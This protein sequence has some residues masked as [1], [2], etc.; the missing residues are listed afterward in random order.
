MDSQHSSLVWDTMGQTFPMP[1]KGQVTANRVA[2]IDVNCRQLKRLYLEEKADFFV[3]RSKKTNIV[4]LNKYP[5]RKKRGRE[6]VKRAVL[7]LWHCKA[8]RPKGS[9]LPETGDWLFDLQKPFS[10]LSSSK[11]LSF[12]YRTTLVGV[13]IELHLSLCPPGDLTVSQLLLLGYRDDAQECL[14]D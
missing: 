12:R 4:F 1:G 14:R 8:Q 5:P 9:T 11:G 7:L 2:M 13:G 3:W 10:V 6:A